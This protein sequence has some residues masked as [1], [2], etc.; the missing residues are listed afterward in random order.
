M[1]TE[2][3]D[4]KLKVIKKFNHY[5]KEILEKSYDNDFEELHTLADFLNLYLNKANLTTEDSD[6]DQNNNSND[7][8]NNNSNDEQNNNDN[9][10]DTESDDGISNFTEN[11]IKRS[12]TIGLDMLSS[13]AEFINATTQDLSKIN[14]Y[15]KFRDPIERMKNFLDNTNI[16]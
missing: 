5:L 16:K 15:N 8:Q 3:Y 6:D 12:Q 7:E 9:S 11:F 13:A 10:N 4:E 14:L 1:S 2:E